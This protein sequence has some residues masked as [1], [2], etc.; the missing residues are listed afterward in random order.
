MSFLP[1]VIGTKRKPVEETS[2]KRKKEDIFPLFE[3]YKEEPKVHVLYGYVPFIRG[4][5]GKFKKTGIGKR[6]KKK[7]TSLSEEA[8][9][10]KLKEVLRYYR[11]K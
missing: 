6:S 1:K 10:K 11:D 8:I 3:E 9:V 2:F 5:D 7:P 4:K